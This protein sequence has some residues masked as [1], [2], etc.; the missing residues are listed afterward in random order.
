MPKDKI[1]K[2]DKPFLAPST[3]ESL[4]DIQK[5]ELKFRADELSF[6][7]AREEHQKEIAAKAITANPEDRKEERSC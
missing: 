7:K 3:I 2:A 6:H 4:F 1:T 5:Q